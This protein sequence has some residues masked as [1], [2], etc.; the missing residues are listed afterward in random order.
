MPDGLNDTA[1]FLV[2]VVARGLCKKK[3][4]KKVTSQLSV[5]GYI[6]MDID[7]SD[8]PAPSPRLAKRAQLF[9]VAR[10]G[11]MCSLGGE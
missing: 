10:V 11:D 6:D 3:G 1:S 2:H 4:G 7:K 9:L 5:G 8:S